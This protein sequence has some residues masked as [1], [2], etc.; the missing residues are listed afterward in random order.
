MSG[1]EAVHKEVFRGYLMSAY[2]R[3]LK[4]KNNSEVF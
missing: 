2:G 4:S 1:V 3:G